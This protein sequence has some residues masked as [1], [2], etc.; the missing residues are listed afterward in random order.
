MESFICT[1]KEG[2]PTDRLDRTLHAHLPEYSR[3]YFQDLIQEEQVLVNGTP[4][5]KPSW[6]IRAGDSLEVFFPAVRPLGALPIPSEDMGVSILYEHADFLIV[7][8]P[9]GLV[10][11]SPHSRST[12][13][14]LVDWLVHTFKELT[15]V[16]PAERPGI[17]HRLDKDTS[18]LMII[19]RTTQAHAYFSDLFQKR[20][21][22]KTYLAYVIGRPAQTGKVDHPIGR[23]PMH[24]HRMAHVASGRSALSNY[25]VVTYYEDAALVEVK[26]HTGR[27]HQIRLHLAS[28]GYP[29]IGDKV[30]GIEDTRI[31]RHALHAHQLSFTYKDRW[32]SFTC[33]M[34]SDMLMLG[35][36]LST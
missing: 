5:R 6:P 16:G 33:S 2:T 7:V 8:K 27:T 10:V 17:V 23:D 30:Y 35:T 9:S 3:T 25:K 11:H 32:Y 4:V 19:P 22:E 18:G 20:L 21:I 31:A 26:P 12:E 36:Q 15:S 34:P 28:E 14:T 1:I 29:L 13:I 24:P